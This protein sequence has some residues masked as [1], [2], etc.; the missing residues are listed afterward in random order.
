MISSEILFVGVGQAGGNLTD[1]LVGKNRRIAGVCINTNKADVEALDNITSKPIIFP[2]AVGAGRDRDTAKG[3]LQD[4][5]NT[6]MLMDSLK[7]YL[8]VK[9]HI[10]IAF[11]LGGGTGS[12][13]TPAILKFMEMQMPNVIFNLVAMLPR[14]EESRLAHA[15]AIACLNE[16]DGLRNIGSIFLIDN[17]KKRNNS[18]INREFATL[19]NDFLNSPNAHKTVIMDAQELSTMVSGRG[20][21]AIYNIDK[22]LDE[23]SQVIKEEV[24]ADSIFVLKNDNCEYVGL[25][26]PEDYNAEDMFG[27]WKPSID[28]FHG[29]CKDKALMIVSGVPRTQA[30][31]EHIVSE[32]QK[33]NEDF[34]ANAVTD[35]S[36]SAKIDIDLP[37]RKTKVTA[38]TE[39]QSI[40]ELFE[41][42]KD[43]WDVLNN[44]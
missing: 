38:Q 43:I 10:Y 5:S 37:T 6:L 9:N 12:G 39:A 18:A 32:Y 11:S 26:V 17:N 19:F 40:D 8:E 31:I 14:K 28:K 16:L 4:A 36:V 13:L 1:E 42:G 41:N 29:I 33:Q 27:V 23:P 30:A 15:N 3:F 44:L 22:Y 21:M 34:K 25:S 7:S 2:N 24:D 20:L 35:G